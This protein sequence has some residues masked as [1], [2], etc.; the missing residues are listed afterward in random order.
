MKSFRIA[1]HLFRE[2]Q[3]KRICPQQVA[4][5][6]HTSVGG[7]TVYTTKA[8]RTLRQNFVGVGAPSQRR[9]QMVEALVKIVKHLTSTST[10]YLDW[11]LFEDFPALYVDSLWATVSPTLQNLTILATTSKLR[12]L[13]PLPVAN[14]PQLSSLN[15]T[16]NCQNDALNAEEEDELRHIQLGI[17]SFANSVRHTLRSLSVQ[18]PPGHDLSPFYEALDYFSNLSS[19]EI[20]VTAELSSVAE[21]IPL[22]PSILFVLRHS[23]NI[24]HISSFAS[25][26]L[27]LRKQSTETK[28]W[29]PRLKSVKLGS[30]ILT[31][32][33]EPTL[34]FMQMHSPTL[35]SLEVVG[36]ISPLELDELITA[37]SG[38]SGNPILSRF[39][40]SIYR[41]D[42]NLILKLVKRLPALKVL[43]LRIMRISATGTS[44]AFTPGQYFPLLLVWNHTRTFSIYKTKDAPAP[45]CR[46]S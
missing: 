21:E 9:T 7:I 37:L 15:I 12:T 26:L 8:H 31:A 4:T 17:A 18:C 35:Q 27:A 22:I 3:Q 28:Y 23:E 19:V 6:S 16:I 2:T 39:S 24:E 1:P 41:L 45:A 44:S 43:Q 33:S 40:I 34:R 25:K 5:G 30:N 46:Y 32:C 14:F 38:D 11:T 13:F 29:Y 42:L 20:D 36:P 10:V